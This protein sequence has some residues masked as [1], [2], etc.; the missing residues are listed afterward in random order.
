M[1]RNLVVKDSS[2]PWSRWTYLFQL[3]QA[4]Q[5]LNPKET[6]L[7]HKNT[8]ITPPKTQQKSQYL[9]H[10]SLTTRAHCQP[11][12]STDRECL[13]KCTFSAS[14][15]LLF[16]TKQ[17]GNLRCWRPFVAKMFSRGNLQDSSKAC[18]QAFQDTVKQLYA[19]TANSEGIKLNC[20]A[21]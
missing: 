17:T 10:I 16:I 14:L 15:V 11:A 5:P 7:L 2:C 1:L 13:L 18:A 20:I 3:E 9:T 8:P 21:R 12:P 4:V 19:F 6:P